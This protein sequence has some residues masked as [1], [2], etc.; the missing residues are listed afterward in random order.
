MS[1][2]TLLFAWWVSLAPE[3]RALFLLPPLALGLGA[4]VLGWCRAHPDTARLAWPTILL[5]HLGA[6]AA[7]WILRPEGLPLLPV[8]EAKA[9]IGAGGPDPIWLLAPWALGVVL[10]WTRTATGMIRFARALSRDA[11]AAP[12]A[13]AER[14]EDLAGQLGVRPPDLVLVAGA[15]PAC[16]GLV[17]PRIVLPTDALAWPAA[18]LDAVLAHELVH[19]VRGDPLLLLLGD[20]LGACFWFVPGRVTLA[21]AWRR[22]V[23]TS[24][25]DDA[26]P[27][28]G[29]PDVY[30][31][32]LLDQARTTG[33]PAWLATAGGSALGERV[34]RILAGVGRGDFQT[35]RIYWPLVLA[36]VIAVPGVLAVPRTSEAVELP[37][38]TIRLRPAVVLAAPPSS[39]ERLLWLD[40]ADASGPRLQP[41]E[42]GPDLA[43][44]RGRRPLPAPGA[45]QLPDFAPVPEA[46]CALPVP[47]TWPLTEP[48]APRGGRPPS[49]HI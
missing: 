15:E 7:V 26:L 41:P 31:E 32:A 25:D 14:L 20:V 4:A 48:R 44:R 11:L 35:A 28:A 49:F 43:E 33:S 24:C 46:P 3:L 21:R 30:A 27:L 10:L 39:T 16:V 6:L 5:A 12:R 22:A 40:L 17:T 8:V 37:A 47:E 18:R 36:A 9:S 38:E 13:L 45:P 19:A 1:S 23:E 42:R 2:L 34:R 29:A